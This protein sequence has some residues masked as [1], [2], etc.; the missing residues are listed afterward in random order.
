MFGRAGFFCLLEA[1]FLRRRPKNEMGADVHP[2][3]GGCPG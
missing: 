1:S 3:F 2:A